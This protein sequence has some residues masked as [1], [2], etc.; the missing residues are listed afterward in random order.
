M[1]NS[2]GFYVGVHIPKKHGSHMGNITSYK[3]E[4]L[5]NDENMVIS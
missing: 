2:S 4:K 5:W 1:T 3:Q